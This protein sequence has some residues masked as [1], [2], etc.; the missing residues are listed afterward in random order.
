MKANQKGSR[1]GFQPQ[2][3]ALEERAA[4]AYNRCDFILKLFR[5]HAAAGARNLATMF[6]ENAAKHLE[7]LADHPFFQPG[8]D[9]LNAFRQDALNHIAGEALINHLREMGYWSRKPR[10]RKQDD[11]AFRI[12]TPTAEQLQ[13]LF[14][15]PR[16]DSQHSRDS[17]GSPVSH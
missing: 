8:A 10:Q 9:R 3:Q 13:A 16:D 15:L 17:G 2:P 12:S 6:L 4:D 14:D 7:L 11:S 5:E 1:K